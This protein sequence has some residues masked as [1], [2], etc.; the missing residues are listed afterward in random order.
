MMKFEEMYLPFPQS[1]I[2]N[3]EARF[4]TAQEI[5]NGQIKRGGRKKPVEDHR[6]K[7]GL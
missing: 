7:Q 2:F 5:Y 1:C 4:S 3:T 6:H